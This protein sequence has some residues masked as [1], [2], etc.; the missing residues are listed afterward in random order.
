METVDPVVIKADPFAP[1]EEG[2]RG[3]EGGGG[4][5]GP[6]RRKA[7]APEEEGCCVAMA[8]SHVRLDDLNYR[9]NGV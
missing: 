7:N 1:K 8:C 3:G 5:V 2:E 6:R 4:R 9:L